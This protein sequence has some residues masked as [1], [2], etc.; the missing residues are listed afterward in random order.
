LALLALTLWAFFWMKSYNAS[1]Q[2]ARAVA[3][4]A[5]V[6]G[7]IFYLLNSRYKLDSSLSLKAHLGNKYLAMGIGAVVV[8]QILFTYAPPLQT[9]F[10][11]E[12]IPLRIWPRL[13]LGGFLFFLVVE[14]EKFI[15]R[16][17]RRSRSSLVAAEATA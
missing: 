13:F 17:M 4:N 10:E 1:D 11:T 3:V 8:L 15:I 12:A 14:A 6:I 2:L 9:L 7:Q 16:S 5:L